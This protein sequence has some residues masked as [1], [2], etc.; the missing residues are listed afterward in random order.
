MFGNILSAL[1]ST[2]VADFKWPNKVGPGVKSYPRKGP[3]R[4]NLS[5]HHPD[6]GMTPAQHEARKAQ[7]D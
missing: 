1:I 7:R 4:A 3:T 5:R 2:K 6:Y